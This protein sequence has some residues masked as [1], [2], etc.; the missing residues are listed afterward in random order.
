M[1]NLAMPS[2][3]EH[4]KE[5]SRLEEAITQLANNTNRFMTETNTNLQNQAASIQNLKV[6]VGQLAKCSRVDNKEIYQVQLKLIL[7]S[8]ARP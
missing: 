5:K 2:S 6:Q 8:N 3:S 4:I 7:R 1:K